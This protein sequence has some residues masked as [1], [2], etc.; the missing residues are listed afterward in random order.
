MAELVAI[1]EQ[2]E[3][4]YFVTS[5]NVARTN[6]QKIK[7]DLRSNTPKSKII[8]AVRESSNEPVTTPRWAIQVILT[9]IPYN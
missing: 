6:L 3:Q 8:N 1:I 2:D 7:P 4:A 9:K 5:S